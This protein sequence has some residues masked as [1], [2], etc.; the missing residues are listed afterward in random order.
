M[1]LADELYR[2]Y[3]A[4]IY[5]VLANNDPIYRRSL[6]KCGVG[7]NST[8]VPP[9]RQQSFQQEMKMQ[10]WLGAQR[11]IE[12]RSLEPGSIRAKLLK[13][14]Q[15]LYRV[16]GNAAD[17]WNPGIWWF[18][19]KV[20]QRCRDESG[21]DSQARLSWLR[22]VLAVCF[23]WSNF[24]HLVRFTLHS[25]EEIP[26]VSGKGLPMPYNKI[27]PFIDRKTGQRVVSIPADYWASKGKTLLG[28]EL[29]IVLPWIPVQRVQ[30]APSL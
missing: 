11:I 21:P 16:S 25:G 20:A 27:D 4:R 23:N 7:W 2:L 29:Q 8:T 10:A 26:A 9:G 28:G 6:Q 13:G 15:T 30:P 24:D 12:A 14:P 3:I 17:Q 1:A 5:P 18:S 22:D 19:E